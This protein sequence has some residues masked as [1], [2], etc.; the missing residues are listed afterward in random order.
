MVI[1]EISNIYCLLINN[2]KYKDFRVLME[3]KFINKI[4]KIHI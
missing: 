1:K 3:K 2:P 4:L